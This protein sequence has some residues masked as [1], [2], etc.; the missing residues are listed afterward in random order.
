MIE[1]EICCGSIVITP[2]N[3]PFF[4]MVIGAH[5]AIISSVLTNASMN[6]CNVYSCI[7]GVRYC[8]L[9]TQMLDLLASVAPGC[10]DT[11]RASQ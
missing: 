9:L 4:S 1:Q 11:K 6:D 7:L 8:W 10:A 2:A 5:F 3:N